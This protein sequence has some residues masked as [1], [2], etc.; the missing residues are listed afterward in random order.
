MG[1]IVLVIVNVV[2]FGVARG[3]AQ[4]GS[5]ESNRPQREQCYILAVG[6]VASNFSLWAMLI[7]VKANQILGLLQKLTQ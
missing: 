5:N 6:L 3:L 2:I 1:I 7:A 4:T